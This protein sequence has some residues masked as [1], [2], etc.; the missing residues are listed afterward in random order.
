MNIQMTPKESPNNGMR[1]PFKAEPFKADDHNFDLALRKINNRQMPKMR[2]AP[3]K[4]KTISEAKNSN[5]RS[6]SQK[7]VTIVNP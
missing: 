3:H 2:N 5:G 7:I 4:S 1:S 6:E